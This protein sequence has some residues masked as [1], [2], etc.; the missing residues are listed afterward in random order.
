MVWDE[1]QTLK[2][3]DSDQSK[4][5]QAYNNLDGEY[6]QIFSSATPFTRVCEAK[7]FAVSTRLQYN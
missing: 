1:C 2:N 3:E 4:R 5:A 6:Y 7:C